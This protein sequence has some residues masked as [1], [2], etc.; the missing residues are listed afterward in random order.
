MKG[1]PVRK[2]VDLSGRQKALSFAATVMVSVAAA[3][4]FTGWLLHRPALHR[5][6]LL[7]LMAYAWYPAAWTFGHGAYADGDILAIA[8]PFRAP[9]RVP[10]RGLVAVRSVGSGPYGWRVSVSDG[11]EHTVFTWNPG[12]FARVTLSAAPQADLDPCLRD[13]GRPAAPYRLDARARLLAT[14]ALL[15]PWVVVAAAALL[16]R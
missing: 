12:E 3:G 13:L 4:G 16:F 5:S 10:W 7:F 15:G 6:E 8:R 14:I 9:V 2:P 11:R 1:T